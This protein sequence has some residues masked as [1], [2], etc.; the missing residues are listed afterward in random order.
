MIALGVIGTNWIS[1][2]FVEAAIATGEYELK[3]VYSRK[4][5][6]AEEFG[7]KYS[8]E[9]FYETD[10]AHFLAGELDVV[11]IASPNSLHFSQAKTTLLAGKHVIVEKPA[12][13]NPQEMA[14]IIELANQQGLLYFEAARNLHETAFTTISEFLPVKG[15]ILGANFTYMK[16]SSRYDQV[17]AGGEPNIFSPQFSG[18]SV[19]DLGIYSLY[20]ALGWFG[21]PQEVYYFARKIVTGVDGMGTIILRY[22]LFDVTIQQGKIADSFLP[23]E[24]YLSDG[25]LLL[26]GINAFET[27]RFYQRST[28]ET[29]ELPITSLEN[30]MVEEA[31]DF[32]R[33]IKQPKDPKL[34]L[35][36]EEWVELSRNVNEVI[37]HLRQQAGIVFESDK[38]K[39]EE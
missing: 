3:G 35:L 38:N 17:L 10:L 31:R 36:Y 32:A 18:G 34:G 30:P 4:L 25:T 9:I 6:T 12:F 1:H 39:K 2:Q 29:K 23:S 5:A 13:S 22:D 27:A 11:Y 14:E 21:M 16:Y 19:Q 20:A 37:Y 26:S 24:I 7:E 8:G 15:Q 33:I 28:G